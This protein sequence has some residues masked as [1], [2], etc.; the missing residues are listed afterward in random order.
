MTKRIVFLALL[1]AVFATA[2]SVNRPPLVRQTYLL[3]GERKGAPATAT[4]ATL[5][6]GNFSVAP[7]FEGKGLVYR[8]DGARYDADFYHEFFVSPRAMVADGVTRWL[9]QSG[10]FRNVLAKGVGG[11][12]DYLLEGHVSELYA[13]FRGGG[14]PAAVMTVQFYLTDKG[15]SGDIVFNADLSR[16]VEVADRSAQAVAQAMNTAFS[17]VLAELEARLGRAG[18][19]AGGD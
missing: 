19:K 10:M 12:A 11:D 8:L 1:V 16:R 14:K 6:V 9:Q 18:L 2:C 5:R 3:Q 4:G 15:G 7:P 17:G 13:D